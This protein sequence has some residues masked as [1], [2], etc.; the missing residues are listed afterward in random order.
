M[1]TDFRALRKFAPEQRELIAG[2]GGV[3]QFLIEYIFKM[4]RDKEAVFSYV[5]H[6]VA[7]EIE[8]RSGFVPTTHPH[9]NVHW[10][11]TAPADAAAVVD[12][13]QRLGPF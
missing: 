9:L 3:A 4:S 11:G 6:P 8:L 13:V 7:L 10:T 2:R 5:G 1:G 12:E